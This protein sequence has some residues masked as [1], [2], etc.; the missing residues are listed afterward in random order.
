MAFQFKEALAAC[1]AA[2]LLFAAGGGLAQ[3]QAPDLAPTAPD[4]TAAPSGASL[5]AS[6][7]P[8]PPHRSAPRPNQRSVAAVGTPAATDR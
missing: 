8:A 4:S 6:P 1:S 3:D 2:L 7:A 5:L